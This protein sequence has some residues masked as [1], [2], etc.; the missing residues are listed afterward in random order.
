MM[1]E[2]K[3]QLETPPSLPSPP[4]SPQICR[5]CRQINELDQWFEASG[6]KH[7][8]CPRC[9]GK[10]QFARPIHINTVASRLLEA[11][12][13]LEKAGRQI[14]DLSQLAE[15]SPDI[16][17]QLRRVS[18]AADDNA[19]ALTTVADRLTELV[20]NLSPRWVFAMETDD[21]KK[22]MGKLM[23]RLAKEAQPGAILL[24]TPEE[25]KLLDRMVKL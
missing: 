18:R 19:R 7:L 16:S 1:T 4:L 25:R 8:L 11:Y 17:K 2:E 24:V 5:E 13:V 20:N 10:R 6:L 15:N 23:H 22:A 9:A 3:P 12:E 14:K 21:Q